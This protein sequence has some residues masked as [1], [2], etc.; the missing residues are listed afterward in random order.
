[1]NKRFIAVFTVT[2]LFAGCAAQNTP[3][4]PRPVPESA[5]VLD[6][7]S[8][9][10]ENDLTESV[11]FLYARDFLTPDGQRVYDGLDA[12]ARDYDFDGSVYVPA[13]MEDYDIALLGTY[14]YYDHPE[15]YWAS[16]VIAQEGGRRVM[17]L[18]PSG[19]IPAQTAREQ[20]A[21]IDEAAKTF[22]DGV[23]GGAFEKAVAVHDRLVERVARDRDSSGE[24]S[25]NIYGA[26]VEKKAM[27]D[28]YSRAYQYLMAKLGVKCV[29][30]Q[31]ES[32]QG[33]PHAWNAVYIDGGWYYVDVTWDTLNPGRIVHS[34]LLITREELELEHVFS[35]GQ[36]PEILNADSTAYNYFRRLSYDV[37]AEDESRVI[38]E[39]AEAFLNALCGRELPVGQTAT[40][41]EAKVYAPPER[42]AEVKKAFIQHPFLVLME[43]ERLA[44]ERGLPFTIETTGSVSCNYKDLMQILIFLPKVTGTQD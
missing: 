29:Y 28:G 31:G 37:S 25:G 17:R 33:T 15:Y 43:M 3:E 11:F 14:F 12:L 1:M 20:Q 32:R 40:Y 16:P 4:L 24:N 27:C 41:L 10:G 6:A 22:L 23:T 35:A 34:Y 26:L 21:E 44:R 36:Y 39:L 7:P 19:D 13:D 8:D 38:N 9:T 30:Y 5:Y 18:A 2:A 42:Y